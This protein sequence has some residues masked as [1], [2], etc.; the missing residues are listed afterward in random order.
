[1]QCQ[2]FHQAS[3]MYPVRLIRLLAFHLPQGCFCGSSET[4]A[5]IDQERT[6]QIAQKVLAKCEGKPIDILYQ[7]RRQC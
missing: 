3:H 6:N 4:V 7:V 5:G 2:P 1:V